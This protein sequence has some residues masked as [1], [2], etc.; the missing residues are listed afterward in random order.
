MREF[1]GFDE[2]AAFLERRAGL[3]R[4]EVK[5]ALHEGAEVIK[6]EAKDEI[7][8]YQASSGPFEAWPSLSPSTLDGYTNGKGRHFPGKVELG[9]AP[10]DNPLLRTGAMRDAIEA[11]V[12]DHEAV[13]GVPDR[14]VGSGTLEDPERNVGDIAFWHEFGTTRM[15]A[16]SFLGRAAHKKAKEVAHLIGR[17][18]FCGITGR[19]FVRTA[20]GSSES[21]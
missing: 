2:L 4:V 19:P 14:V 1:D 15:P 20:R 21:E 3:A 9:Y 12:G 13:I 11:S 5:K 18:F 17:A 6:Q 7:G 10:P 16:R 8:H